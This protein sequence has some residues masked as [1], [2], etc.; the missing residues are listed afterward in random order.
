MTSERV[1]RFE[2]PNR[3]LLEQMATQP[4]PPGLNETEADMRFFRVVYFDTVAGDLENKGATVRLHIDDRG[5]QTL[6]VDVRDH[7]TAEGAVVRRRAESEVT[8]IDPAVLFSGTSEPARIVRSLIDPRRLVAALELEVTRRYRAATLPASNLQVKFS[9]DAVTLRQGEITGELYE[10]EVCLPGVESPR[11]EGMVQEFE[12]KYGVRLTLAET[13]SRAR[14]LL[15]RLEIE[16]LEESVKAAREVA[17]IGYNRGRIALYRKGKQLL[18]PTGSGTGHDAVRRV[19]SEHFGRPY[20]RIRY[21]GTSPGTE[22]HPTVETWL[23]ED[24][25]NIKTNAVWSRLDDVL[26]MAGTPTLRDAR[27]LAALNA[28]AR[29]NVVGRA[30]L[31]S[32]M[33]AVAEHEEEDTESATLFELTVSQARERVTANLDDI[34]PKDVGP[35][36]L[37]NPEV[38]R[39]L[40]DERILSIIEDPKTPL[41]ERMKF[42]SMF[43]SRLD[44]FFMTRIAEFKDQVADGDKTLSLD[45]LTPLEQL[46]LARLRARHIAERAYGDLVED[47]LPQLKQHDIDIMRWRDLDKKD[48]RY[49]RD[50]YTARIEAVITPVIADPTHPFPH[51]RNLRP[52]IAAVVKLPES[53]RE[54][55]VAVQLPGE[56]PRF[57][58]LRDKRR[59]IP[60]EQVILAVLPNLYRGLEVVRAHT[61]RVTRS[62]NL[63]IDEEPVGGILPAVEAEVARRP[64]GE[65]VRLEVESTMPAPMRERIL[66]ELQFETPETASTLSEADVHPVERFVDLV[67]FKQIAALDIPRLK[68]EPIQQRAPLDPHRSVFDQMRE[69]EHLVCFPYDSFDDSVERFIT[70]AAA[71]DDVVSIKITLYRTDRGSRIVQ[72]LAR[73]REAGKDAFALVELKA[74]FDERRNVE[75]ARSLENS[76]VHVVYSPANF[77]VHA[78]VALVVRREHGGVQRYAYIGTGNM[79]AATAR[80]YTDVGI[81]TTD[82][83]LT[84]DVHAVFNLLT[85]YSSGADFKHLLVSPFNMRRRFI[86]LIDREI[87]HARAGRGGLMRLQFNGLAD[88]RMISALYRAS[89]AGVRTEMAVREIC[90]LRPGIPGISDNI[91]VV[92]KL[93][94]F[95]Q[96]ARIFYFHNN[97]D[98]EYYIGS[99]DWRPR[100]LSKRV[101]VITPIR[102]TQHRAVLDELLDSCLRD[103]NVWHLRADGA[104]ERAGEIVG[105]GA[106]PIKA[107]PAVEAA[108]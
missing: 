43:W 5:S 82:Q 3:E 90:C 51:I 47:L 33:G 46:E 27:T 79:N 59:F 24:V 63:E 73:A 72:A 99:A 40:F 25:A 71:D 29:S 18:V 15:R 39:L 93:G 103:P 70:D 68:Y 76:G 54:H 58:P 30:A 64:F 35:E 22:S 98:P 1:L 83:E 50:T 2:I 21:L 4:L 62:G 107:L 20:G 75:W 9:G 6:L 41:L 48:Q 69:Q 17:V 49:L 84:E 11:F 104:Y 77:K 34:A 10:L 105:P 91:T 61:F 53:R 67:A 57:V 26:R 101:E 44:D 19:L 96:H 55:F 32:R 89:Q 86:E 52:A 81:L 13:I 36:L 85:G 106:Q 45:A 37:L 87:E 74:S 80:G 31:R 65:A 28:V 108:D 16:R 56:L 92:S 100:N 23:A 7:V 12:H 94:R 66:R 14:D 8:G 102:N 38:S 97:G 95:L 78:K 88:R 60:L 42:L